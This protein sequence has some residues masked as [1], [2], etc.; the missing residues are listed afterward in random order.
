[1]T[2]T[3]KTVMVDALI[4]ASD[5]F[6]MVSKATPDIVEFMIEEYDGPGREVIVHTDRL[7]TAVRDHLFDREKVRAALIAAISEEFSLT[8]I[9]GVYPGLPND[10]H[11]FA[12]STGSDC[13][14]FNINVMVD[15]LIAGL[16]GG[17]SE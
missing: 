5:G 11:E 8:D 16:A 2:D 12:T 17:S 1:M 7:A 6:D 14:G 3:L 15:R 9:E 13:T 10:T 4:E